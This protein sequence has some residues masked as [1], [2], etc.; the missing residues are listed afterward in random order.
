MNEYFQQYSVAFRFFYNRIVDSSGSISEIE[1]RNLYSSIKNIPLVD[2]WIARCAIKDAKSLYESRKAI[3]IPVR[4]KKE[5]E[6]AYKKRVELF[7]KKRYDVVFGGRKLFESLSSLKNE[8][9]EL[10]N[11]KLDIFKQKR[12]RPLYL[13]GEN[14]QK[15]NRKVQIQYDNDNFSFLFKPRLKDH[16]IFDI[17]VPR[18]YH[19]MIIQLFRIQSECSRAITYK[20]DS[21]YIHVSFDESAINGFKIN[22]IK[23]RVIAIDM[24]PNYIGYSVVQWN[25]SSEYEVIDKGLFSLKDLNVPKK[26][27]KNLTKHQRY[28]WKNYKKKLTKKKE[29]ELKEIGRNLI[30]KAIHFKCETFAIE[31]LKFKPGDKHQGSFFNK[32]CN[33]DW[34]I[35]DLIE[36]IQKW[37]NIFNIKF[38]KVKSAYSSVVENWIF[39]H[40]NHCPDPVL[41]SIEIGR[42]GYETN[43][44]KLR[45]EYKKNIMFPITEDFKNEHIKSMEEFDVISLLS[46]E[47][48]IKSLKKSWKMIRLSLDQFEDLEFSRWKSQKS[49]V[50]FANLC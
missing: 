21:E 49:L 38:L 2:K 15:G 46:I 11:E 23:N 10:F 9:E 32:L 4:K 35:N 25:S 28:A 24:N 5:T 18:R 1:L 19:N 31:D 8:N 13:I 22:P 36:S 40:D 27:K 33:Q 41:A 7:E 20:I 12:L 3:E 39:R 50:S 42:R 29:H 34:N 17:E 48:I 16:Y 14:N 6:E 43:I 26:K 47:N 37:C 45:K 30:S 44:Q